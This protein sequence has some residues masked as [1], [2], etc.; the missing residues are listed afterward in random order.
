MLWLILAIPSLWFMLSF[1][2][3]VLAESG[4]LIG[5]SK[6]IVLEPAEWVGHRFPLAA[7][8]DRPIAEPVMS[9]KWNIILFHFDCEKCK[10]LIEKT[11]QYDRT[12]FVEIPTEEGN[13][14]LFTL[15]EY[16][17]LSRERQWWVQTPIVISLKDGMVQKSDLSAYSVG[18]RVLDRGGGYDLNEL[19][20]APQ[21]HNDTS[22]FIRRRI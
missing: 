16:T 14:A 8:L 10:T 7:H 1:K 21:A 22:R 4:E 18:R 12:L 17:T 5:D 11:Q 9:G 6:T 15:R 2:A 19:V 3:T 20:H 13:Q